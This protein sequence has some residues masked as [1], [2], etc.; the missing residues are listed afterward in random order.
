M[1]HPKSSVAS[2]NFPSPHINRL[3]LRRNVSVHLSALILI[4]DSTIY[5]NLGIRKITAYIT[6]VCF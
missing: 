5:F 6:A 1:Y 4:I 3:I 2:Q